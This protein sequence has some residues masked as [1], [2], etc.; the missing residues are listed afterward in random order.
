GLSR[1]AF[2]LLD[3]F[4]FKRVL[5]GS[6]AF[7]N[8]GDRPPKSGVFFS[9]CLQFGQ[10]SLKATFPLVLLME[11]VPNRFVQKLID[12]APFDLAEVLALLCP[13]SQSESD[14]RQLSRLV[15][16]TA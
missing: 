13:D 9:I 1:T 16:K 12:G 6:L 8:P 2:R 11:V 7:Y 4:A 15:G 10:T 5:E 3:R 14:L